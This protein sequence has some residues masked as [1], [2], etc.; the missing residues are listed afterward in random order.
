VTAV[1]PGTPVQQEYDQAFASGLGGEP[2]MVAAT[3][4]RIP[5]PV[6]SGGWPA[7]P[8]AVAPEGWAVSFTRGLL[9]VDYGRVSRAALGS[10]LVLEEAQVLL[11][12]DPAS[13]ANK[14]L[15]I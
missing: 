9:D 14:V 3:A 11:P 13:L 12:G 2:G 1:A 5:P 4:L 6:V 8:V 10:W 7:L 15:Y